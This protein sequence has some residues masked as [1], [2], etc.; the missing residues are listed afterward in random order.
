M[1]QARILSKTKC[2]TA[3]RTIC[4]RNPSLISITSS[5]YHNRHGC[6]HQ[7]KMGTN[8]VSWTNLSKASIVRICAACSLAL[9]LRLSYC[10]VSVM[11]YMHFGSLHNLLHNESM[12]LE[13]L[14]L[15]GILQDVSSGLRFLHSSETAV[16]HGDLKSQNILVD[17]KMRAKV[18]DFGCGACRKLPHS[19]C[20]EQGGS[21][22]SREVRARRG[23]PYWMA[24]E[25]L[26]GGTT[27][28][29][30]ES[31]IY[32]FGIVIYEVFSRKEPYETNC[33]KK[34]YGLWRPA[35]STSDL[36]YLKTAQKKQPR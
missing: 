15:I 5:Q 30:K 2:C 13:E 27:T 29:S 18:A 10:I 19:R 21:R 33:L 11:E 12:F 32:S 14:L 35:K 17:D 4:R 1:R 8:A 25:L 28:N 20:S 3:T 22:G 36:P 16:L 24:P 7:S 6:R 23:T 9:S 34:R 31:D 26:N